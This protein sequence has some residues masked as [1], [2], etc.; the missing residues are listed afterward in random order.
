[1][2]EA[3]QARKS[4]S[5][6]SLSMVRANLGEERKGEGIGDVP[7]KKKVLKIKVGS[8]NRQKENKRKFWKREHTINPTQTPTNFQTFIFF[9]IASKFRISTQFPIDLGI[10]P[11]CKSSVG[12]NFN[13]N[14][15]FFASSA[16]R[17]IVR[18]KRVVEKISFLTF[19]KQQTMLATERSLALYS[20]VFY[21]AG[22]C[23]NAYGTISNMLLMCGPHRYP[24]TFPAMARPLF[25]P[26]PP[27]PLGTMIL[28]Y[29]F[30]IFVD[31][32]RVG[33]V[34]KIPLREL[35]EPLDFVNLRGSSCS[36]FNIDG[37]ELSIN[38]NQ[39][40]REYLEQYVNSKIENEKKLK[41]TQSAGDE[42]EEDSDT[43][44]QK[45]FDIAN[46]GITTDE[47]Q[48]ADKEASD[49]LTSMIEERLKTNPLPPPPAQPA[50]DGSTKSNSEMPKSKDGD[51]DGDVMQS[52]EYLANKKSDC[53]Y[54]PFNVAGVYNSVD[55]AVVKNDDETTSDGKATIEYGKPESSS[56]D[57]RDD[58]R[59][60]KEGR[61]MKQSMSMRSVLEIGSKEKGIR[62]NRGNMRRKG[63]KRESVNEGRRFAMMKIQEKGGVGVSYTKRGGYGYRRRIW[64]PD[65]RKKKKL[66][67][68]KRG[69]K[70]SS[71]SS[72][73]G[74]H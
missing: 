20:E 2:L 18:K 47:D 68:P 59:R 71:F 64:Q 19:N 54:K 14:P 46:S 31:L 48:E 49:K 7:R 30:F 72:N 56:P 58:W 13:F 15:T 27:G 9:A 5:F 6:G 42:K 28:C 37:Q 53:Y 23:C 70:R 67:R 66:L 41:E 17:S 51:S 60:S 61:L 1:M 73:K 10:P 16:R 39:A 74:M 4:C 8:Y 50:P 63:R 29:L 45:K 26:C 34:P 57:H 55:G 62:R 40:T 25:P 69:P 38:V 35:L 12:A 11:S 21:S 44:N 3:D 24:S 36:K 32:S 33:N 43:G 52:G 65:S 22:D